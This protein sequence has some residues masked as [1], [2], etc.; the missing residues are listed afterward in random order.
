MPSLYHF[1]KSGRDTATSKSGGLPRA[2]SSA[3][4]PQSCGVPVVFALPPLVVVGALPENPLLR[5]A[6][7][8]LFER[9]RGFA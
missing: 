7:S 9:A 5:S 1:K 3:I 6:R 8:P 4:V 2:V